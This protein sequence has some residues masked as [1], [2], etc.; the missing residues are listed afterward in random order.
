MAALRVSGAVQLPGDKSIS[1]RALILSALASGTSRIRDILQSDDVESTAGALR[2]MGTN[3]AELS[4]SIAVQGRGLRGLTVPATVLDCGNSGT[5]ARL[6][7][8]V[9]AGHPFSATLTGDD[10][11][12]RRPM[13]RVARPLTRM[14]ARIELGL[15]DQLP[16][17]VHGAD[18][19][20]I[21]WTSPTA[22]AQVKSAVLLAALCARVPVTVDEPVRSR[23]HT[24]RML[25]ALGA[26]LS[27][28]RTGVSLNHNV[29]LDPLDI[30]VPR[31]PSAAAFMAGL[32]ALADAGE[33][34]L[35]G[36]CVN[37]T[38][39]GFVGVLQRM[40]AQVTLRNEHDA[41]SEPVA[42]ITVAPGELRGASI[43]AEEIPSL[44]DELPL[45]ACV[46]ARAQGETTIS[47]AAELRF[48][49]SDRIAAIVSNLRTLG[50]EAEE[51]VDGLRV[52]GSARPLRGRVVTYGDHR[53]AMAFGVLGAA[54]GCDIEVDDLRCVDV[55]YPRFWH[56]LAA[57]TAA[58]TGAER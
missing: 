54:Q 42:D 3:I 49:E 26:D 31:D 17:T 34:T 41:S 14:G 21:H 10:S 37:P 55:S 24:E 13:G 18:L 45:I 43:Q 22:S 7:A 32:A 52:I 57:V 35:P 9:V 46:A 30:T 33:L 25:L 11:L 44:I 40:G 53:I 39:I 20:G 29:S 28:D 23:D 1:H 4:S 2:A 5:T 56:D 58:T 47:G 48:K 8:G 36:V 12:R 51:T 19:R 50:A 38:R 6:L 16:M 27:L 15:G